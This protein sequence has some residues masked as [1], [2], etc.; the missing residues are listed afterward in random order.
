MDT[1][2]DT[3]P[4]PRIYRDVRAG[5]FMPLFPGEALGFIGQVTLGLEPR[6]G[7]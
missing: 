1:R 6:I 5:P 7:E 4:L 3:A 2:T